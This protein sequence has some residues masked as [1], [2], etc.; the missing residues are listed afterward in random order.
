MINFL[1]P[2]NYEAHAQHVRSGTFRA[3]RVLLFVL[4]IA[5]ASFSIPAKAQTFTTQGG[6]TYTIPAGVTRIQVQVSGAGGG[7]G[8][9]DNARGGNGAMVPESP[10]SSP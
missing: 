2:L 4:I 8:G 1:R 7:G 3:Q 9:A 10:Q 5:I 6:W